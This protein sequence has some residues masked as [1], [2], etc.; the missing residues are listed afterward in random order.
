MAQQ[1]KGFA[2]KPHDLSSPGLTW[3]K[4]RTNSW[5]LFLELH[6]DSMVDTR[7][8]AHKPT[9]IYIQVNRAIF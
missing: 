5:K 3:R 7:S 8:V 6:V 4:E 9:T 2:A 1:I